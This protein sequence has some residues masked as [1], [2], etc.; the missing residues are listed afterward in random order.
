MK[1]GSY[2]EDLAS[3]HLSYADQTTRY[4]MLCIVLTVVVVASGSLLYL[5]KDHPPSAWLLDGP[6]D[7]GRA[8]YT[9]AQDGYTPSVPESFRELAFYPL[10]LR[11]FIPS[12]GVY[13]LFLV[14][15]VSAVACSLL[16]YVISRR[17]YL[18]PTAS[19]VFAMIFSIARLP[20]FAIPYFTVGYPPMT[21]LTSIQGSESIYLALSLGSFVALKSFAI[22]PMA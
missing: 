9:I 4:H 12:I 21:V 22:T 11:I 13:S 15:V 1:Q 2:S 10:I 3:R 5:A 6:W 19:F 8:F 7:D 18:S 17:W 16:I 14:S 20:T